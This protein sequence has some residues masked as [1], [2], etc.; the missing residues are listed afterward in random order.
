MHWAAKNG[1]MEILKLM[2]SKGADCTLQNSERQT[3]ADIA[4][5]SS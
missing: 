3:P 1:N 2:V 4:Q 5:S